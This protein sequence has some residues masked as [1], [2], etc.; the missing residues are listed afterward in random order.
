MMRDLALVC[1]R[2]LAGFKPQ[3]PLDVMA[4]G[5]FLIVSDCTCTATY[6]S[7]LV[8]YPASNTQPGKIHRQLGSASKKMRPIGIPHEHHQVICGRIPMS[9]T[10]ESA[11]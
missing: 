10:H 1:P 4:D 2:A 9:P 7:V 8:P 11:Y 5:T 3:F 6:F